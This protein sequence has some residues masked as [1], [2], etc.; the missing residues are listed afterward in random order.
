MLLGYSA[1]ASLTHIQGLLR[2]ISLAMVTARAV[3]I[4]VAVVRARRRKGADTAHPAEV[5]QDCEV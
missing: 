5:K 2:V 1:G 4:V 3:V